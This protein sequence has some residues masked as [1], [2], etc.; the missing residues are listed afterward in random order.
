MS[1]KEAQL[2][3]A[4]DVIHDGF[5]K[6]DLFAASPAGGLKASV[7]KFLT[8]NFERNSVL[9]RERDRSGKRVHQPGDGGTFLG[10]LDEDL[11][12]L[13]VGVKADSDVAFVPGDGELMRQ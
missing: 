3:P 9:K 7:G 12:R 2:Q 5:G 13:P 4:E 1:G 10:H 6:A 8:Q 11:A